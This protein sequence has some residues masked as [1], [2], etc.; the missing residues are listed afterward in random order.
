MYIGGK[1]PENRGGEKAYFS[2]YRVIEAMSS[3]I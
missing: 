2:C 3:G 1:P